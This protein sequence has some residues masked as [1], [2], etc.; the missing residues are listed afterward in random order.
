[1]PSSNGP[2]R[3]TPVRDALAE[4]DGR[5]ASGGAL[6]SAS[7]LGSL[8]AADRRKDR[9]CEGQDP[10]T[11]EVSRKITQF[12]GS[13]VESDLQKALESELTALD[14]L[15]LAVEPKARTKAAHR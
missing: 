13:L 5:H 9:R 11:T 8:R 12:S 15:G 3:K 6:A 14:F 2:R 10:R 4:L 1:M 7:S